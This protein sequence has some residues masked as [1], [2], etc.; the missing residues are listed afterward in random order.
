MIDPISSQQYKPL[1]L[2]SFDYGSDQLPRVNSQNTNQ[3]P[4][5]SKEEM[6]KLLSFV[7]YKQTG[8]SMKLVRTVGELYQGQNLDVLT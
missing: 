6:E 4:T 1:Y 5:M 3:S 7:I 2:R 8:I